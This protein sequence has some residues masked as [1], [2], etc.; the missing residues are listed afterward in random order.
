VI[1]IA[2]MTANTSLEVFWDYQ[3]EKRDIIAGVPNARGSTS[4]SSEFGLT[5]AAADDRHD[6]S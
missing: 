1:G 3:I 5:W 4:I 6:A 2:R